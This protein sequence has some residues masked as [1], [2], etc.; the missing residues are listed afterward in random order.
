MQ[1]NKDMVP[2]QTFGEQ[3]VS[4]PSVSKML[5]METIFVA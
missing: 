5:S 2:K 3:Q 4:V 1:Y